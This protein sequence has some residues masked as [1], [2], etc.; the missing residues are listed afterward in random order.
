MRV[1]Q[2]R[3]IAAIVVFSLVVASLSVAGCTT[4]TTST[5]NQTSSASTASSTATHAFL[6]QYL[7]AYKT[8]RYANNSTESVKA[9]ELTWI[10]STSARV[11]RTTLNKT[12]N[13][14]WSYVDIISVFPTSDAATDYL[15]AMNKTAYS[16][17]STEYPNVG[18]GAYW[19]V[20]GHAPQIYKQ[21]EW[22]EGA[23]SNISAYT[24]H[25]LL[26]LDNIVFVTTGKILS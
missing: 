6:E 15:N 1:M 10:N 2:L 26:Q 7:A 22:N 17:T 5:T 14:T 4:S 23:P 9:W 16:L 21:Y 3:P 19:N 13:N 11:G 8:S 12:T 24:Y 18:T 25:E 20:T